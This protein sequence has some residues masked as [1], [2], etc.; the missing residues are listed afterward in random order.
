MIRYLFAVILCLPVAAITHAALA[1]K[2]PQPTT[3]TYELSGLKNKLKDNAEVYLNTL[4]KVQSDQ[5]MLI[6]P[7]IEKEL[8]ASLQALGYY[9]ATFDMALKKDNTTL[10][11]KVTPGKPIILRQVN[12]TITGRGKKDRAFKK[13]LRISDVK[14]GAVLNHGDYESFKSSLQNLALAKGYFDAKITTS[15]VKVYPNEHAADVELTFSS[16]P[17][18][19]FGPI[20]FE[21]IDEHTKQLISTM[22]PFKQGNPFLS[23]KLAEL[24]QDISTTGYFNRIEIYSDKENIKGKQVPI[25]IS[26]DKKT[27]NDFEVGVGYTTDEGPRLFVSWDKPWVNAKGHSINS[28]ANISSKLI[29]LSSSYNIPAGHPLQKYYSLQSGYQHKKSLDTRSDLLTA[30]VSRW[31]KRPKG[32]DQNVFIRTEYETYKQG[33]QEA[34]NVQLIPGISLSRI[35]T[36]GGINPR[37]GNNYIMKMELSSKA[38]GSDTSFFRLWGR[39]KWLRSLG[40]KH[41]LIGRIEQGYTQVSKLE[42]LPP[43]LRFFTGGDLS[44]RGFQFESIS[45]KDKDENLIG[46]KYVT[47]ASIEHNYI[48]NPSWHFAT[49][50]DTGTATNTYEEKWKIGTGIG[51]RWLTAMG[52]VK[53]DLAFG[54]SEKKVPWQLHF[55]M[56]AGL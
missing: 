24:N 15:S 26:L 7:V 34:S 47:A 52:Q 3:I 22:I 12:I 50:V 17:R 10:L 9:A 56:G 44:V 16:G 32:W 43:S 38:L 19:Q 45:P 4:H 18:Y 33:E 54:V 14:K 31:T 29:E 21:N 48:I 51:I 53:L 6:K 25:R 28:E 11:I 39:T 40:S 46:A 27:R 35:Q 5:F 8:T 49:F 42:N 13:Q 30:S 37:W 36:K 20:I 2:S 1:P 23:V 41:R 55:S